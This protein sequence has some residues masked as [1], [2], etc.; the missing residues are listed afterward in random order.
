MNMKKIMAGV[1]ASVFAVGT[2]AVAASADTT[3]Y[4]LFGAD[5]GEPT[6]EAN[7]VAMSGNWNGAGIALPEDVVEAAN[8]DFSNITLEFTVSV[9]TMDADCQT[10]ADAYG[11]DHVVD[12]MVVAFIGNNTPFRD[13]KGM[14]QVAEEGDGY[15]STYTLSVKA[16]IINMNDDGTFYAQVQNGAVTDTTWTVTYTVETADEPAAEDEGTDEPAPAQEDGGEDAPAAT[17]AAPAAGTGNTATTTADKTNADTGVEGVAVV[18]GLAIVAAG[19]VI[20]AK[21]RK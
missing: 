8:G 1:V 16:S 21:K 11:E 19:A 15:Q 3:G 5:W 14:I 13:G 17:E 4:A 10:Q 6:A 18:A 2:M 7:G 9:S 20:V 12:D